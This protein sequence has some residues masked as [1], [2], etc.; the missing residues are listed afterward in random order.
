VSLPPGVTWGQTEDLTAHGAHLPRGL[1]PE[2]AARL[3]AVSHELRAAGLTYCLSVSDGQTPVTGALVVIGGQTPGL[4]GLLVTVL[5]SL[6]DRRCP[7]QA[8]TA[9]RQAGAP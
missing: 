6:R 5:R 2:T 7:C 4:A 8:C 1:S 3:V 9:A